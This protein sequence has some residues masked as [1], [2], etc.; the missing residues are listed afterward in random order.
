MEEEQKDPFKFV[1]T[2]LIYF[3]LLYT[4]QETAREKHCIPMW[5]LDQGKLEHI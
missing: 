2:N 5:L 1:F 3:L 4:S